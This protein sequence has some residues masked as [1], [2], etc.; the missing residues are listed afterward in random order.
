MCITLGTY[1]MRFEFKSVSNFVGPKSLDLNGSRTTRMLLNLA[2]PLYG[3]GNVYNIIM[4][5]VY[6][7]L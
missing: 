2:E 5:V 4:V 7:G 6:R 1:T 3:G